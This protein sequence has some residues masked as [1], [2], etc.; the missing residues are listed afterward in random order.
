M[1]KTSLF[2]FV[3]LFCHSL[4]AQSAWENF[5][6]LADSLDQN[7]QFEQALSYRIKAIEAAKNEAEDTRT[8]LAG[9]QMFTQAEAE[10]AQSKKAN[11]EAYSLMQEAVATLQKANAK[12]ERISKA[13][14]NLNL[15]AFNYMRN[16]EDTEKYLNKSIEYHLKSSKIDTLLLLNTMHGSAYMGI[17]SSNFEKA[18]TTLESAITI[19]NQF[20]NKKEQDNNLLGYLYS[21]L[22]LVYN[23]TFLDIPQKEKEYLEAAEKAFSSISKPDLEYLIGTYSSLS[24]NERRYRDYKSAEGYI[25]KALQLYTN[26]KKEL[27]SS[28]MHYLGFKT[29][30]TL[31]SDL[32]IIYRDIGE[33]EK[34]I[35]T[36][37]KAEYI[38]QN[39][40]LD[41]TEKNQYS[42]ILRNV[43]RY[44]LNQE[45]DFEKVKSFIDRALQ[46]NT[47]RTSI[48][49]GGSKT[50]LYLDLAKAYFLKE[51]FY[52]ALKIIN[53]T[54]KTETLEPYQIELKVLSLLNLKKLDEAIE[55]VNQLLTA[56]STENADLVFPKSPTADFIPGYVITDA[57]SLTNLAKAFRTYYGG[58]SIEEEKL[59]WMAL[60]QFESNIA[61]TPLNKDLKEVF[62]K[63][64]GGLMHLALH[65]EFSTEE[66][67]RLLTFMESIASQELI[68]SFLL[69]RNI[70]KSTELYK[71]VEEEQYIRSYLTL[72]KKEFVET[73]SESLK[74]QIFEKEMELKKVNARLIAQHRLSSL[75][76]TPTIDI[77][78]LSQK[79]VVKFKV[80]GDELFKIHLYNNR[81]TYQVIGTFQTLKQEVESFLS[82]ISNLDTPIDTLKEKG[83][84]LYKKLFIDELKTAGNTIII[85]DDILHYLPFELL[86]DDNAYLIKNHT[87]SY[88]PNFYFLNVST[89]STS[90][91]KTRKAIFFAPKY[92]GKVLESQLA[93]RGEPYS[94]Q[95][96]EEEIK[97]IAQLISGEMFLGN[98]ASKSNFKTLEKDLS[99][100][101]LAMH[102]NL[103]EEDPELSNLL[104]SNSEQDYEM[105]ISELYGLHFNA[106]LAVLSACNTGIGG[107]KDGGNLVSMRQAF[108]TAGIAATIASLWN[109]PDHSTKEIMVAFYRNLLKGQ[110][111]ATA[112]QQAKL[113]YLTHTKDENLKHPFYWA[114]FVLSGDET[115]IA[116]PDDPPFWKKRTGFWLLS[117]GILTLIGALFFKII[118]IQKRG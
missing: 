103:N 99:I 101:H 51:D 58:Y 48:H 81:V 56:I 74:Q 106:D 104:F 52:E 100:L 114:G 24:S 25:N 57:E 109:A 16:Q 92:T 116:F 14:W 65:R 19:F 95:G 85:A 4:W 17:L 28:T 84:K 97:E 90:Y 23:I 75:F 13:Y 49:T 45:Y 42:Q 94:L 82:L 20:Q 22:A 61:N 102:S 26:N 111:K 34:M 21:D 68:N 3:I 39:N 12:P 44:Y 115:P 33:R 1:K 8:M 55:S 70:A 46:I 113:S 83:S 88:A 37:N 11:P 87:I 36:F 108:T 73:K 66:N 107:F 10:F 118:Q 112:L 80:S 79:N 6:T 89:P 62:D 86:V 117:I 105:Y 96:A 38:A 91:S 18:I 67:N 76:T 78:T 53:D 7:L 77:H 110:D 98:L 60:K 30:L 41:Q 27:H 31:L 50:S 29:E 32:T 2:C 54:E 72:L 43:G 15:V 47:E 35:E 5:T 69:K 9:L 40:Q 59:Y 93:V 71:L 63:I 64:A